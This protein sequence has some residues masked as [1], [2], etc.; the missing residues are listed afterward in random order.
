MRVRGIRK[1]TGGIADLALAIRISDL[2]LKLSRT[3]TN[4]LLHHPNVSADMSLNRKLTALAEPH[5]AMY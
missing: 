2:V 1:S 4:W 3:N 5:V